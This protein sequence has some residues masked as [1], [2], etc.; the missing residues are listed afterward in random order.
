MCFISRVLR[1]FHFLNSKRLENFDGRIVMSMPFV[2]QV[3]SLHLL[4]LK[5]DVRMLQGSFS[6]D[7][8]PL[9]KS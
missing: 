6:T 3:Q 9:K 8:E 4:N 2:T 5:L 1:V 7:L